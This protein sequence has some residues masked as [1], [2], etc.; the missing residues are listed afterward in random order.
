MLFICGLLLI[1]CEYYHCLCEDRPFTY[2]GYFVVG[3]IGR[4]MCS[5]SLIHFAWYVLL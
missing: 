4:L 1:W 3:L 2:D 5:V